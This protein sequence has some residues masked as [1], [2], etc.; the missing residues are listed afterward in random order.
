[1]LPS[2]HPRLH[3][4]TPKPNRPLMVYDGDCGFCRLWI[5]RWRLLTG[6][7]VDYR[8]YQET[9]AQYPEISLERFQVSVQLIEPDGRVSSGALAVCRGLSFRQGLGW[10]TRAYDGVPGFAFVSEKAYAF[11]AAHRGWFSR[12][13]SCG[14][15]SADEKP[16]YRISRWFFVKMLALAF[17]IAFLSLGSQVDGLIGS[18]GLLPVPDF[19]AEVHRQA[20]PSAFF[21]LPTLCWLSSSDVFLR[22]LC[23]AGA[24]LSIALLLDIAPALCLFLLWLFYLSL[25]KVGQDFLNFQWD[26]LLLEAALL[27]LLASPLALKPGSTAKGD[28]PPLMLFLFQWLLFRL[29][30]CA[31]VVKLSSGDASWHHLTA[32]CFHYHT[33]PLPTPLAWFMDGLPSWFQ[34]LSCAFVF[35]TELAVPFALWGPRRLKP[36]A[37]GFWLALQVLIALTG[38]Y[39]F[40]N[41][42]SAG[43]GLFFLED[44]AWPG[45]VRRLFDST[46]NKEKTKRTRTWPRWIQ[47]LYLALVLILSSMQIVFSFKIPV[48]WPAPLAALYDATAPFEIVNGY[49]L[50]AVMTTDR[51]EIILEGSDD[52]KVWKP[53]TFK[54]KPGDLQIPPH[55]SAPFQPRLDWQMWF[56]ALG[57]YR[58]N[59]WFISLAAS[60]LRGNEGVLK[61]MDLNPFP[62]SPPRFLWASLYDYRF[63][64]A[65]EKSET[66]AWWAR[67]EKGLYCPILSL[68][69][70]P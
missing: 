49:G 8:P 4:E 55:W 36:Y 31:G 21:E 56:A 65:K 46:A 69:Q 57:T 28:P 26:I 41:W 33:Q 1:M 47:A 61:L 27:A 9:A 16:S 29:I 35:F 23:G 3:S 18:T 13:G 70:K 12:A 53:Y 40:F 67:E 44:A 68:R 38:N 51:P 5:K 10:M 20:G 32:L 59:P 19:L 14:L 25:V 42:V 34:Q 60:L 7:K 39:C 30:F 64:T 6:E 52:G 43:L 63:T 62:N 45:A 54:Y 17:L 24:V 2:S 11:V 37:F 48:A 22:W 58:E 15:A 66:G 50:F